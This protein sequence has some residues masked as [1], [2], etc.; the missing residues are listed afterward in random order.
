MTCDGQRL[1]DIVIPVAGILLFILPAW[2]DLTNYCAH[3]NG[4][5]F[6]LLIPAV[7]T[8]LGFVI[9]AAVMRRWMR[10]AALA[11]IL[12]LCVLLV[13]VEYKAMYCSECD[14]IPLRLNAVE[15]WILTASGW[16]KAHPNA[17]QGWDTLYQESEASP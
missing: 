11:V 12:A 13:S 9:Y 1:F 15:N 16:H 4:W 6:W 8:I 5:T 14:K 7:P 10:A 3:G 2:F 17:F